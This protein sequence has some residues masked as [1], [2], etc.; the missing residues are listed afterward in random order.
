MNTGA[1]PRGLG[2]GVRAGVTCGGQ[3]GSERRLTREALRRYCASG[4]RTLDFACLDGLARGR[5][6]TVVVNHPR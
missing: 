6:G 3:L 2:G 1:V 5:K 4:F